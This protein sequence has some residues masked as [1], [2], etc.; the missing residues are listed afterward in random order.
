MKHSVKIGLFG[1]SFNPI[2]VG[3]LLL[4]ETARETL[5][6]DR[7]LFIPVNQPP[8]KRG[9]GLLPGAIRL[10]LI[11]LAIRDQPAFATTEIELKR[12]G[13]S[14]SIETVRILNRR[15]PTAELFLLIGQDMLAV[16]WVGW[17]E[18]KRLCTIVAARRPGARPSN[19]GHGHGRRGS[20]PNAERGIRWLSMPQVEI[21]SSDIRSR[22][23][24]GRSIRYLVPSSVERYLLRHRVYRRK[25]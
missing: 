7:V 17:N 9:I 15:L 2:H 3:H 22:A 6:L 21:A 14:Y 11:Q 12:P 1:G 5:A 13:P 16:P 24:S 10:K 19:T 25:T 4:A 18:L 8:H 20:L 23:R